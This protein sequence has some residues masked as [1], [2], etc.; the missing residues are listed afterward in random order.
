MTQHAPT[1]S[2]KPTIRTDFAKGEKG[3]HAPEA[4]RGE[5]LRSTAATLFAAGK[6]AAAA[7]DG[8]EELYAEGQ[9]R[10]YLP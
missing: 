7:W 8:A 10:A 1:T 5:F 2:P 4:A 3:W 6:S 9:A